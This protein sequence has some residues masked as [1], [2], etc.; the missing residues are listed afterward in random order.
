MKIRPAVNLHAGF[1]RLK[2]LA[3]IFAVLF[4]ADFFFRS[5]TGIK[6]ILKIGQQPPT[7]VTA[8]STTRTSPPPPVAAPIETNTQVVTADASATST[9][10]KSAPKLS[11]KKTLAHQSY[12]GEAG[13]LVENTPPKRDKKV[14]VP[15]KGRPR[16]TNPPPVS[17]TPP[18]PI[19]I[20]TP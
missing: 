20:P 12:S 13:A 17:A 14:D 7:R 8:N 9:N 2:L 6:S 18:L 3:T 19:A 4:V 5:G 1:S 10:K 11:E 15:P 16:M